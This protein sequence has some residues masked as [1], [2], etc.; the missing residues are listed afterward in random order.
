M[1]DK[2][3]MH[4]LWAEATDNQIIKAWLEEEGSYRP[5]AREVIREEIEKRSL[6]GRVESELQNRAQ[7]TRRR[8][9]DPTKA[10]KT[11][12]TG[13]SFG[14]D[15]LCIDNLTIETFFKGRMGR[16]NCA[17]NILCLW[18]I[19]FFGIFLLGYIEDMGLLEGGAVDSIWFI[20]CIPFALWAL[21][22]NTLRFHDLGKPG[23]T[24][25]LGLIPVYNIFLLVILFGRKGQEGENLYGTPIVVN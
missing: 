11:S 9:K 10:Q 3:E 2:G 15:F 18:L 21:R 17:L 5:E 12:R 1:F 19:N 22:V 23:A 24:I 14:P 8:T 20:S 16:R 25:V 7:P 4:K 13:L 6:W